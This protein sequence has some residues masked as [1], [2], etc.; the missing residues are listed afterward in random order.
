MTK[1]LTAGLV[2]VLTLLTGAR[3]EAQIEPRA[4]NYAELA[5]YPD[6]WVQHQ[7]PF[8]MSAWH[9]K[10]VVL[11][12]KPLEFDRQ[13]IQ[14]FVDR[15]DGGWST[16]E[17][18]IGKTPGLFRQI[19]GKA[20]IC[21]L[22][23]GDLSCG[24][25]CGYVGA[26]GIEVAGFYDND[27]PAFEKNPQV[28]SH[29]Y[30]YELGRN[31]Y[32]F[33]DR[34]SLF[35][36]GY[37]VFMRYVCM[38]HLKCEDPDLAT[39]QTIERCEEVYANSDLA[40]LDVFTNLTTG[41]KGN[42]LKDPKTGQTISPSDQPVMYATAMLK[43]R[44]D[45]GGDDWLKRFYLHLHKCPQ[46]QATTEATV[47]KQAMNWLVCASAAAGEDL[48]PVFADRWRMPLSAKQRAILREVRWNDNEINVPEIIQQLQAP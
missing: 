32:V 13:Q 10:N 30:F 29:Y 2:A 33:E 34:H 43:L 35:T 37:A 25:G 47:L 28:F 8:E 22:P 31:F 39:R 19:D 26:T 3:L 40:F 17:A 36:T 12:T 1:W 27:W 7:V 46:V 4:A 45:H 11:L 20:T 48:S 5:F 38:D 24:Y 42:R 6:R 44:K 9:G 23:R 41:E 15:L 18:I 16:Y 21:A 14:Q